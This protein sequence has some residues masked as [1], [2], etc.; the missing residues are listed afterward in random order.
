MKRKARLKR[1]V[2]TALVVA[3]LLLGL[4][5]LAVYRASRQT[6]EFYRKAMESDP[7]AQSEASHRM[8]GKSSDLLSAMKREGAW[9]ALF[10]AEEING[11]LAVDLVRNHPDAIP[12][13]IFD[14]RIAINPEQISLACRTDRG[15][16]N[17]VLSLT[18]E[19]Y[20]PEP[21]VIAVRFRRARLGAIPLP[22]KQVLDG[23]TEAGRQSGLR[24]QWH[25]VDGDPVALFRM[26][27]PDR[28]D[29]WSV[30]IDSLRLAEG[31]IYLSGTVKRQ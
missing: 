3:L 25:Q 30:R 6:P 26:P 29:K 22:L 21:N 10:T 1:K 12:E 16:G 2:F 27:P 17:G 4:A 23:V 11:W 9:H 18:V 8:L 31:E 14:P 28:G 24:L 19:P 5:G 20:V 7:A 15:G 13:G